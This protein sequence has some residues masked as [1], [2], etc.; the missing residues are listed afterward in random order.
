MQYI[1][2]T[3]EEAKRLVKDDA[4]VLVSVQDLKSNDCNLN[5]LRKRFRECH[6]IIDEAKTIA[7]VHGDLVDQL[8]IFS[9]KQRDVLDYEP[10]GKLSTVLFMGG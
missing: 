9:E 2:M 8:K 7:K 10:R 6:N 1:M 3:M 4:I 5:F